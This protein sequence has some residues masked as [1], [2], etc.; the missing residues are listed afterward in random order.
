MVTTTVQLFESLFANKRNAMRKVH[1]LANSVIILDE[2]QALPVQLLDTILDGLTTLTANCRTSVVLSTATQPAFEAIPAFKAIV[3]SG[4]VPGHAEHFAA[5]RRVDWDWRTGEHHQ[6]SEVAEWIRAERS[7]LTIVNTVRHAEELLEELDDPDV[8]HLS[9]KLC[10]AHR[11]HVLALIKARLAAGEPCTVVATTVVEAGVDLDF[12][13]VFRALAPVD[14]LIQAAGRCNREGKLQGRGRV[15]V[16]ETHDGAAP[17]GAYRTGRDLAR[18]FAGSEDLA[19]PANVAAASK[20]YFGSLQ[21]DQKK[22]QDVRRTYDFP[23]V[24]RLFRMID[25]DSYDVV[26]LWGTPEHKAAVE[27]AVARLRAK[28]P[29]V[30]QLMR[31]LQPYI[32]AVRASEAPALKRNG[33]IDEIMPGLG[34][35]SGDY[36]DRG[37]EAKAESLIF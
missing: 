23:K 25:D 1:R 11:R 26:V 31:A 12:P 34:M 10:G 17:P 35:W 13:V 9:R 37:L 20:L 22:I 28:D 18:I 2:A 27:E 16:F 36:R 15:I 24:A 21:T 3:A 4:I 7:S 19:D 8:F 6:W 5:L 30:R 29:A 14:S 32:V 33:W